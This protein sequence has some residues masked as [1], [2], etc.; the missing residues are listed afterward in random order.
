MLLK[1]H[2]NTIAAPFKPLQKHSDKSYAYLTI[3]TILF[4]IL[5]FW[6]V[7]F[8]VNLP[9]IPMRFAITK[10]MTIK[11]RF[12]LGNYPYKNLV[13]FVDMPTFLSRLEDHVLNIIVFL[14]FGIIFPFFFKK[15]PML[16]TAIIFISATIGFEMH[17]LLTGLGGFDVT[18][19]INNALGGFIG[20]W[21]YKAFLSKLQDHTLNRFSFA[22]NLIATPIAIYAIINTIK[23]FDYY[24]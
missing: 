4:V 21:L 22:I 5:L 13:E 14:P 23:H 7:V 12:E 3:T 17:Q 18:D 15:R 10:A 16:K 1:I 20:L 24:L 8:K 19:L 11:E 6:I 2:N 9:Y